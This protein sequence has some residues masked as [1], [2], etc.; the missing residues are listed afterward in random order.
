[1]ISKGTADQ[2]RIIMVNSVEKIKWL[3]FKVIK[4]LEKLA[5]LKCQ[6][7]NGTYSD[8]TIHSFIGYAPADDPRFI[9]LVKLDK[10][11]ASLAGST[12]V[13]MFKELAHLFRLL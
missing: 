1:V 9:I 6:M 10:P 5:Q 11:E 3:K 4:L 12:V 13:P 8:K 7:T 2:L